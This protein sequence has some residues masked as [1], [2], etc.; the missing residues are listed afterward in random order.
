MTLRRAT[1]DDMPALALLHRRTVEISLPFVPHLHTP[2]EDAWWFAERLYAINEVWLAE[3]GRGPE[4]YIAFRPDFIEHLFVRPESQGVG[5]G[6]TLLDKAKAEAAQLSLWTFQQN[7]RAR[8]F[9][10]RQ[11]FV[12]AGETDGRDNEEKL[13]DVLYRWRRTDPRP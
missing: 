9:Y 10:E 5:L 1:L 7:V 3:A 6:V 13:P 12:V 8:R 4:A 11:G 2:E